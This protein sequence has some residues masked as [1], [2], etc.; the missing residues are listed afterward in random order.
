[1]PYAT[2]KYPNPIT[3]SQYSI[4]VVHT[5]TVTLHVQYIL[6]SGY[7]LCI[8][9]CVYVHVLLCLLFVVL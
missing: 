7:T 3:V 1:M 8:H 9:V 2:A 5:Y 4:L 6:D